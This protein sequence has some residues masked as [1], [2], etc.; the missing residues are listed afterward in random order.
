MLRRLRKD[1]AKERGSERRGRREGLLGGGQRKQRGACGQPVRK[2]VSRRAIKVWKAVGVR[3]Q[4]RGVLG[5]GQEEQDTRLV[6]QKQSSAHLTAT[7]RGLQEADAPLL[8]SAACS[9]QLI[10]EGLYFFQNTEVQKV[11]AFHCANPRA[12]QIFGLIGSLACYSRGR[13]HDQKHVTQEKG[14]PFTKKLLWL[15]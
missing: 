5:G 6:P 11:I 15:I 8:R 4:G 9:T 1:K 10:S 2:T 3:K 12:N 7:A 14:F 13:R